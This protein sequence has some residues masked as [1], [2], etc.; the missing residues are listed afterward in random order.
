MAASTG[1]RLLQK[2]GSS[3]WRHVT[4]C[5]FTRVRY[6]LPACASQHREIGKQTRDARPLFTPRLPIIS[7]RVAFHVYGTAF[8]ETPPA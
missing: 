2:N 8:C 5:L 7:R 6:G 1:V 4:S 3:R